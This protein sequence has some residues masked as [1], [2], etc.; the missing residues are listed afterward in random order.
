SYL[1]RD[2]IAELAGRGRL[3]A[4]D[5][6]GMGDSGK[7]KKPRPDTYLFTTPQKYLGAFIDAVIAPH[8][9]LLFVI[10]DWGSALGFDWA[11]R[12]RDRVRGIAYM[13]GIVRP[14][15][16]AD[17][18]SKLRPVLMALRSD[19]GEELILNQNMSNVYFRIWY[20]ENCQTLKWQNI[21][22][23]FSRAKTV[24]QL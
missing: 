10:H 19:E 23:R 3:I 6:I 22:G 7:L 12:H 5:L 18:P 24:G 13:E 11:N 21:A 15:T 9:K 2:V 1:W 16:A 20:C 14:V 8:E 4:P 17:E